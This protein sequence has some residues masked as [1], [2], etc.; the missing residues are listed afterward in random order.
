M[1]AEIT[2]V[3]KV[4]SKYGGHFWYMFFKG[5][6]GKSYKTCISPACRNFERWEQVLGAIGLKLDKLNIKKGNLIDADSPF[7]YER[8]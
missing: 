8:S 6:D 4:P 2:Q 7:S 1:K 5:E 3:S